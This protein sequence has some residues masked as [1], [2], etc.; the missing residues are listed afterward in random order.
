MVSLVT[1]LPVAGLTAIAQLGPEP[2]PLNLFQLVARAD[3]VALVE[4]H[5]GSLKYALVDVLEGL[6]GTP[7]SRRL[8]IAFRDFNFT[9]EPGQDMIVFPNGQK[10]ILFLV[11]YRKSVRKSPLVGLSKPNWQ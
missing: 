4:V 5:E 11:P 10:E 7:P 3:L 8:R 9:R 1:L 2:E 6:K